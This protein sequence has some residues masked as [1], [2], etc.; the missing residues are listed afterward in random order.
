MTFAK[1]LPLVAV[2]VGVFGGSATADKMD[3]VRERLSQRRRDLQQQG[4]ISKE[5]A[6]YMKMLINKRALRIANTPEDRKAATDALL[7]N[8]PFAKALNKGRKPRN[9]KPNRG[10][11]RR[12]TNERGASSTATTPANRDLGETYRKG[13]KKGSGSSKGSGSR[14]VFINGTDVAM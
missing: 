3:A 8:N 14:Y 9:A 4:P 12:T 6:E 11:S 2:A 7:A 1:L 13:S 5:E 10:G